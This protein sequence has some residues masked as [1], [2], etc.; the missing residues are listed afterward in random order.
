MLKLKPIGYGEFARKLIRA[1]YMPIRKSKHTIYFHSVKNITIP[2]PHK[3]AHDIPTGLLN[4][5]IKE[6]GLSR[7]DFGR[8]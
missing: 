1:G 8:L 4:K 5:L 7:E 3:H 2:F 6:M